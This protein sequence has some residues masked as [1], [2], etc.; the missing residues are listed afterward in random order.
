MTTVHWIN[1]Q[2]EERRH[3]LMRCTY[4]YALNWFRESIVESQ[5]ILSIDEKRNSKLKFLRIENPI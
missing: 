5:G 1:R 3:A 4:F 2:G